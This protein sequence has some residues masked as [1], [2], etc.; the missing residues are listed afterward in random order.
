MKSQEDILLEWDNTKQS[1]KALE[2][3]TY[4]DIPFDKLTRTM[5]FNQSKIKS[6]RSVADTLE[7]ILSTTNQ[8]MITWGREKYKIGRRKD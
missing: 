8:D 2:E 6:L 5:D 3:E 7:W 4:D 1:I